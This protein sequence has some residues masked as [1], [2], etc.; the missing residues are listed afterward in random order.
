MEDD[1]YKMIGKEEDVFVKALLKSARVIDKE[2]CMFDGLEKNKAY[3]LSCSC[4]KCS[5]RC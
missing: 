1:I 3:C 4:P 5:P 2:P